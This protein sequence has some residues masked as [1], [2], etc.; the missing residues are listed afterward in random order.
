MWSSISSAAVCV[1]M[2]KHNHT[3]RDRRMHPQLLTLANDFNP[4]PTCV[5]MCLCLC[6]CLNV[7]AHT[8]IHTQLLKLA[9]RF[10]C[11][12]HLSPPTDSVWRGQRFWPAPRAL[13]ANPKPPPADAI[14]FKDMENLTVFVAAIYESEWYQCWG[15]EAGGEEEG[16][17]GQEAAVEAVSSSKVEKR[18]KTEAK[19]AQREAAKGKPPT[20]ESGVRSVLQWRYARRPAHQG[21]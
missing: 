18:L 5:F 8:N 13:P 14:P 12:Y 15:G 17:L 16:G 20:L 9:S 4:S 7:S 21:Q 19:Q 3:D 11:Y 6:V 10:I 2:Q 1:Q